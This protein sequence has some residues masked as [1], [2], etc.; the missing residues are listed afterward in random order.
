LKSNLH[1][2][3]V[4][5]LLIIA[6]IIAFAVRQLVTPDTWGEIG[7]YRAEGLKDILSQQQVYQSHN[8]NVY[9]RISPAVYPS[10]TDQAVSSSR[11][12][13]D[14][15]GAPAYCSLKNTMEPNSETEQKISTVSISG[16]TMVGLAKENL[17]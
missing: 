7:Y 13:G 6:V 9:D 4:F 12:S 16:N 5:S 8:P 10:D 17:K 1:V 2:K 14:T 15:T 3:R 11:G